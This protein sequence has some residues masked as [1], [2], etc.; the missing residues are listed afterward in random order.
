MKKQYIKPLLEQIFAQE[1]YC[2]ELSSATT[3]IKGF[4]DNTDVIIDGSEFGD[5]W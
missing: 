4:T 3:D 2:E 5:E 1:E